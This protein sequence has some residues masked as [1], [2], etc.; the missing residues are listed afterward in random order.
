MEKRKARILIVDDEEDILL[1]LQF[2]LSQHFTEIITENNPFQLPRLL[3][4]GDYDLIM[5][6]MN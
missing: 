5:L 1:S 3:R 4:N 2:F 6:D